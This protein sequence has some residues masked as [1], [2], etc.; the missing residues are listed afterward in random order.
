MYPKFENY[1]INILAR[2]QRRYFLHVQ[3]QDTVF[4]C[5][6]V[7]NPIDVDANN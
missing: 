6:T 2:N 4:G 5:F 7:I 3:S 1:K